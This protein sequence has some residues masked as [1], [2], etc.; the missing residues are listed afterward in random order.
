MICYREWNTK[1]TT[2]TKKKV[3][4]DMG[5]REYC[6]KYSIDLLI[7]QKKARTPSF[8]STRC[9]VVTEEGTCF[10]VDEVVPE[11]TKHLTQQMVNFS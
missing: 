6:K 3:V 11:N 1:I 10:F 4:T 5:E 7:F 8:L 9:V 2:N